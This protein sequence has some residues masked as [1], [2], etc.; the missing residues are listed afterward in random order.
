[1]E[2]HQ[3]MLSGSPFDLGASELA[4]AWSYCSS[5]FLCQCLAPKNSH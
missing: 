1:M 2:E 5:D 3:G 4:S